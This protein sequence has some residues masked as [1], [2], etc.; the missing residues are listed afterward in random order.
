MLPDHKPFFLLVTALRGSVKG[1]LL[2]SSQAIRFVW[3]WPQPQPLCEHMT[4]AWLMKMLL[5][6]GHSN[7]LGV[8]T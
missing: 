3:G 6:S 4:S 1:S 5:F 8:G 7:W 2:P